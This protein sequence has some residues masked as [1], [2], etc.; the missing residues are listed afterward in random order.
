MRRVRPVPSKSDFRDLLR[1]K[2]I[3]GHSFR[4]LGHALAADTTL[5]ESFCAI[6]ATEGT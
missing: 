1:G 6:R 5:R 4:K 3:D 2:R